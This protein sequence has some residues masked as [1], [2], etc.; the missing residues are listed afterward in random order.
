MTI[1]VILF[2]PKGRLAA[3]LSWSAKA[4]IAIPLIAVLDLLLFGV[5]LLPTLFP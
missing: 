5:I 3:S 2:S 4:M 1:A